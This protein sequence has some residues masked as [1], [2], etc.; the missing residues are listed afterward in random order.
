MLMSFGLLL[1]SGCSCDNK[2]KKENRKTTIKQAPVSVD[3]ALRSRLVDFARQPRVTGQFGFH[4]YDLTADK[5]VFGF[6]ERQAMSSA[7]CMKLLSGVAGLHLLGTDHLYQTSVYTRGRVEGGTL[8]GDVAF[9]A[10]LDPQLQGPDMRMF[11][12]AVKSKGIAKIDGKLYVD[13]TLTEP[14]ESEPHWYPWDL[15]FSRYGLLYKGHERVVK[16]LKAALRGQGVSVADSQ[17]VMGA[18]PQNARCVYRYYRPIGHVTHR[19]WKNSSNVQAT[20]M[21]YTIG[22]K[23]NPN[24]DPMLAGVDYLRTFLRDTLG[25]KD[26]AL[27]IHDGCGLCTHNHLS[28]LALTTILRF[29]YRHRAIYDRLYN[30]L[31]IAGVDGTLRR[32]MTSAKTRGKIRAKT[33]TL[34]HPYGIS[35]LAGYCTGSNGHLLAFAIMDTE[36]SVL[37][38]RVLQR[39]LCEA[40]VK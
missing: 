7:S 6:N 31:P 36:M 22:N 13:L 16:E 11:A 12:K 27:V 32:E 9:Q 35:S 17:V 15:S 3:T 37:D 40:M 25:L 34:S 14:V 26:T 38:A 23:V 21:L 18:V 33:G 30:E 10:G 24:A 5:P 28:P 19:M 39:K 29:G 8:K 1:Y 4:V 20:G 2:S